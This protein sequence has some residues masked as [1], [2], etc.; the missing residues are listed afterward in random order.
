VTMECNANGFLVQ[1][2][3][4]AESKWRCVHLYFV[5]LYQNST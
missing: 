5:S 3:H 1:E 2:S 4:W